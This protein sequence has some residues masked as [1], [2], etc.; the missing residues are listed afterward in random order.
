MLPSPCQP[1]IDRHDSLLP[2]AGVSEEELQEYALDCH[3]FL[4]LVSSAIDHQTHEQRY[5]VYPCVFASLCVFV[6]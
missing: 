5:T 6:G 1:I 3:R 2:R 4:G